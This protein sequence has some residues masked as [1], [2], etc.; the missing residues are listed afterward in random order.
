MKIDRISHDPIRSIEVSNQQS[1]KILARSHVFQEKFWV[2][3]DL[4]YRSS[5][6]SNSELK[7]E[8]GLVLKH[9]FKNILNDQITLVSRGRLVNGESAIEASFVPSSSGGKIFLPFI[10][11]HSE[12]TMQM[13]AELDSVIETIQN[14]STTTMLMKLIVLAAHEYGHFMSYQRG[15]H[16]KQL[17][18]GLYYLHHQ[19]K[20]SAQIDQ[21][22]YYVLSE[23]LTAWKFAE[24]ILSRH[25][26]S[27]FT[28]FN[29]LRRSS[30]NEY[31]R[32]MDLFNTKNFDVLCK[33]SML[34]IN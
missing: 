31:L 19:S 7:D 32:V 5:L 11:T 34:K 10:S 21:Y 12:I 24:N 33:L 28:M 6:D 13:L 4:P 26:L 16:D 2:E 15:F 8:L 29:N 1:Q 30:L 22:L 18:Q 9:L 17:L 27:D 3:D 23:E 20:N 14:S 25:Q